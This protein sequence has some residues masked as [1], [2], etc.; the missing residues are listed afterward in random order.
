[1]SNQP[2]QTR[3]QRRQQK[4]RRKRF[5]WRTIL[6]CLLILVAIGLLALNPIKD[7][8]IAKG[9]QTNTVANLTREDIE[10]NQNADVT[11]D[12]DQ[13]EIIDA[14][15]V[16][17]D[18]INPNDLPTIGG[19]AIPSVDLNLPINKGTANEGMYY[20]AGTM[21][22][23][24][25][26]GESNYVLA[27]HHSSNP[28]LLFAPLM[29]V[30]YGDKIYLTDLEHIFVYEVDYIEVVSPYYVEVTYP[31]EQPIV[32]LITCTYDLENRFIVR[33]SLKEAVSMNQATEEMY[34]AFDMPQTIVGNDV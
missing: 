1:M 17:K 22:P 6:G 23:N 7:Y 21:S 16:F 8:L 9:S 2:I 30:S 28:K 26:M 5:N 27:S 19:I 32:T 20:G 25:E 10:R 14:T 13:I 18:N 4:K 12:L 34:Q 24:Q 33:G 3:R 15:T 11:F 29:E 31:T